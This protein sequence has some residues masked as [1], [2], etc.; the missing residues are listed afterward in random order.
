MTVFPSIISIDLRR[1][2][3]GRRDICCCLNTNED[4]IDSDAYET[5]G[6]DLGI[7]LSPPVSGKPHY[8][9]LISVNKDDDEEHNEVR[10]WSLH[11][12]LRNYYIPLI[13]QPFVKVSNL[14]VLKIE[15]HRF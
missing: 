4:P 13:S 15:F 8:H 5:F 9:G 10:P 3:S 1:R 14:C 12:I 6:F 11:A 2:K 7:P